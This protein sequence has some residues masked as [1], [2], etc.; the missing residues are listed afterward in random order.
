MPTGQT[1]S[2]C[3]G[4]ALWYAS[5]TQAVNK[6]TG[7]GILRVFYS[8]NGEDATCKVENRKRRL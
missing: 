8:S 2:A 4:W 1:R 5:H 3:I 7:N 6:Y